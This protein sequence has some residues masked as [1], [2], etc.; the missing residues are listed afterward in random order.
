MSWG[1]R[2]YTLEFTLSG[3][4]INL[5]EVERLLRGLGDDLEIIPLPQCGSE[6]EQN[7]KVQIVTQDPTIIFDAC[8]EF[9]RIKSIKISDFLAQGA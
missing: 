1:I 7:Y 9:G 2:K 4:E 5:I 6:R 8:A 3:C